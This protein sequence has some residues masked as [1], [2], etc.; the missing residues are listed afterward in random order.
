MMITRGQIIKKNTRSP[1]INLFTS[2]MIK[3][4][5]KYNT[6]TRFSS[7]SDRLG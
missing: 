2:E 5:K 6:F 4:D 3:Q 7:G 1:I